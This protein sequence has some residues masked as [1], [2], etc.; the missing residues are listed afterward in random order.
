MQVREVLLAEQGA[1]RVVGRRPRGRSLR[2]Q[3]GLPRVAGQV[4]PIW[5]RNGDKGLGLH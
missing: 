5:K 2:V 3:D 1:G 4:E